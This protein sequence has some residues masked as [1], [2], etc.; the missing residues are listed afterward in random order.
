MI[1]HGFWMS[2]TQDLCL[3]SFCCIVVYKNVTCLDIKE[4]SPSCA[5]IWSFGKFEINMLL[6]WFD[7]SLESSENNIL[8]F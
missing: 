7:G 6:Y 8:N 4:D 5:I 2:K 3:F 1:L